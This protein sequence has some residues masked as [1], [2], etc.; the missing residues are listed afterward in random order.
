MRWR[1]TRCAPHSAATPCGP[2]CGPRP[3]PPPPPRRRRRTPA[4]SAPTWAAGSAHRIRPGAVCPGIALSPFPNP[5]LRVRAAVPGLRESARRG[6]GPWQ[7]CQ[8][9]ERRPPRRLGRAARRLRS[10]L[11]F[12]AGFGGILILA[13]QTHLL[14]RAPSAALACAAWATLL[15]IAARQ[16]FRAARHCRRRFFR[17]ELRLRRYS[18]QLWL[19]SM[20]QVRRRLQ[21]VRRAA[22]ALRFLRRWRA[23][24]FWPHSLLREE[25]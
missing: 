5:P 8:S 17:R 13:V 25:R 15:S 6:S 14:E 4:R 12:R 11:F 1:I 16:R 9:F 23:A 19:D 20:W 24:E 22:R 21:P 3:R 10:I 18:R 7:P 2:P